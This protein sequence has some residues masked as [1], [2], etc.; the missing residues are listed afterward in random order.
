MNL[1]KLLGADLAAQVQEALKGKGQDG[2]DIELVVGNDGS[3][4]PKEKYDTING[5]YR[6]AEQ[7]AKDMKKQ[8]DDLKAAGDPVELARQLQDAQRAAEEAAA[9]HKKAM[10]DKD[11]EFA[12]KMSLTNAHDPDLVAGLLDKT[13]L[14]LKEDGSIDGLDEQLKG[15]QESKSFLFKPK[16]ATHVEIDGVAPAMNSEPQKATS[17]VQ[18]TIF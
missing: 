8:L 15:L 12:V 10:A 6:D 16:E 2:K 11:M 1:E 4:L 13:K 5:K 7:L 14:K 9:R 18:R 3:Y 17:A